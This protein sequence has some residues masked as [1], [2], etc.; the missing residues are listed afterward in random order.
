MGD[1]LGEATYEYTLV[2]STLDEEPARK[3][4]FTSGTSKK[5]SLVAVLAPGKWQLRGDPFLCETER[6]AGST[7]A[8]VG[9]VVTVPD[10]CAWTVTSARGAVEVGSGSA[11]RRGRAGSSVSP[12]ATLST[13]ARA[14]VALSTPDRSASLSLGPSS[15]VTVARGSCGAGPSL[16]VARGTA[17]LTSGRGASAEVKAGAARAS[18]RGAAWVTTVAGT[19]VTFAVA[20]GA[21]AV[22][23]AGKTVTVPAGRRTT[24]VGRAAPSAPPRS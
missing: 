24:V 22:R 15:S 7:A 4:T 23:A 1:K 20:R 13:P 3:V 8:E 18:G 2:A 11:V 10:Y 16:T 17:R 21:V 5:G 14:A 19:R 9:Q 12:P 6:G